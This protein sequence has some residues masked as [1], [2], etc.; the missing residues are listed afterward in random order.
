MK[1]NTPTISIGGNIN[2]H[3][4]NTNLGNVTGNYANFSY[5][6]IRLYQLTY[7]ENLAQVELNSLKKDYQ[8]LEAITTKYSAN[9]Q[10]LKQAI[11]FLASKQILATQRQETINS[12][13]V[14]YN[15]ATKTT[16]KYEKVKTTSE[17]LSQTGGL[18][19]SLVPVP[20]LGAGLKAL[21]QGIVALTDFLKSR[22]FQ[23]AATKL[24]DYL[25]ADEQALTLLQETYQ[26]VNSQLRTE[27]KISPLIKQLLKLQLDDFTQHSVFV[28]TTLQKDSSLKAEDLQR[29]IDTLTLHLRDLVRDLRQETT[30]VF[31]Q[32]ENLL[33][34]EEGEK[35]Q[36]ELE[37]LLS[38][39]INKDKAEEADNSQDF[40]DLKEKISQ[41]EIELAN[42]INSAKE[43]LKSK[44]LKSQTQE[45]HKLFAQ[46]IEKGFIDS[47]LA[48]VA[49]NKRIDLTK[50]TELQQELKA[51][52]EQLR[53]LESE[54]QLAAQ[55]VQNN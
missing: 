14:I 28:I 48:A 24:E 55:I 27:S 35:L 52:E 43:K 36:Q 54:Q 47:K 2:T 50:I 21:N 5:Q 29:A 16:K 46:F 44:L 39:L 15:Q 38:Q 33:T 19:T 37:E 32:L 45:R 26:A 18:V 41:Q 42:L 13:I 12:L 51:L 23:Q 11:L 31:E 3:N 10:K 22:S 1:K 30:E 6:G 49:K 53:V 7:Q 17:F 4:G 9:S 34:G 25:L 20:G 8:N 40:S